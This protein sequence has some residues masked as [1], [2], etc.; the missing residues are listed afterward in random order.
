ME[1]KNSKSSGQKI[2]T[3]VVGAI[4]AVFAVIMIMAAVSTHGGGSSEKESTAKTFKKAD[5]VG[6][7]QV[8]PDQM[9]K[10]YS[11]YL[12][13]TNDGKA[14]G[15]QLKGD[16]LDWY[17]DGK[18]KINDNKIKVNY[19]QFSFKSD[20]KDT[21]TYSYKPTLIV[22]SAKKN[23]LKLSIKARKGRMVVKMNRVDES[24]V[25]SIEDAAIQK[26][27]DFTAASMPKEHTFGAGNYICGQDFEAGVYDLVSVS[28]SGNVMCDEEEVNEVMGTDPEFDTAT[29]KN[30]DFQEGDMLEIKGN[31]VLK[32]QP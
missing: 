22:K 10:G 17:N 30:V 24:K 26:L 13:L 6:C 28:G 31:L 2:L 25:K 23:T 18:Y 14:K 1:N 8:D 3:V 7:W 27:N 15:Y 4:I 5:I 11:Q 16:K 29:Y 19:T 20:I 21:K 32:L 9:Q 12:V